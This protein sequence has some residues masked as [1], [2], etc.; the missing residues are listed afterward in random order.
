MKTLRTDRDGEFTFK[1][2][3][4]YC[5]QNGIQRQLIVHHSPQQNGVAERNNRTIVEMTRSMLKGKRRL[6][7]LWVEA[8]NTTVYV[9]NRSPTKVVHNMTPYEAWCNW[10]PI[11]NHLSLWLLCICS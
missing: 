3:M 4:N 6:N 8:V 10:K 9:L 5:K 7:N 2:F 1:P 11:V